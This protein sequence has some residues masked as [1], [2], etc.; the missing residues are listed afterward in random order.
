M[1]LN[2][3]I[4]EPAGAPVVPPLVIVH[5]LFGSARN[6]GALAKRIAQGH[7]AGPRRVIAVD[8]RNHG[9][10]PWDDDATYPAL[11]A[12]LADTI[13]AEVGGPADVLGHSM[14][15]KAAMLLA[16]TVP[17]AVNRLIIADIAPVAYTG[18]SHAPY[19]DAMQAVD[20]SAITRRSQADVQ[21]QAGV[22]DRALRAFLLQSLAVEGG[23]ARWKLNLTALA[24]H[25]GD[26]LSFP[27]VDATWEGRALFVHGGA[28]DYVAAA[29][30]PSVKARFPNTRLVAV[31]DAG[32]WL[33][34][35]KPE[36][37]L[38]T[39]GAFLRATD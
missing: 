1:R 36:A 16:L 24:A 6:W 2:T 7:V 26:I 21:L 11:A 37:F 4:A 18:H 27:A 32:H 39:V 31:K 38:E 19:I 25:M 23:T 9:D 22:P 29:H 15:G 10:S 3:I 13:A 34:A 30:R 14:G 33:H 12:D 17:Q 8:L 20:L 35:D 5:G 28:S